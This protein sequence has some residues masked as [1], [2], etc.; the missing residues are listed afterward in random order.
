MWLIFWLANLGGRPVRNQI[1]KLKLLF[2]RLI[3]IFSREVLP[4]S[5]QIFNLKWRSWRV[6]WKENC[7]SYR[8]RGRRL[9]KRCPCTSISRLRHTPVAGPKQTEKQERRET[10]A[11]WHK[12]LAKTEKERGILP[13]KRKNA[14][15]EI[16]N[17][18]HLLRR[19]VW[20]KVE[21]EPHSCWTKMVVQVNLEQTGT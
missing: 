11:V 1:C 21:K 5:M 15:L 3:S 17:A 6:A 14:Q 4:Q 13:A 16:G 19:L 10:T 8:M 9:T 7:W 2:W 20:W 18:G 12:C